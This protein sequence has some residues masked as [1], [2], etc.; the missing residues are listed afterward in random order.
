MARVAAAPSDHRSAAVRRMRPDPAELTVAE[1]I[2]GLRLGELAPA[3]RPYL[4]ANMVSSVDG[5]AAFRGRTKELGT[6]VD[7]EMF[8]RLRTHADAILVGAH[9]VRVERYGRMV[10]DP[11]LREQRVREGLVPDPLA[12]IVSGRLDLPT[13]TTLF[14]DPE[15][16]VA[17]YTASPGE[18]PEAPAQVTVHRLEPEEMTLGAVLRS[19]RTDHAVRSVLCEGGPTTLGF[20]L[21][22][23]LVDELFL[24]L[25]PTLAGGRQ[26][27]TIVTGPSLPDLAHLELVWVLE[28]GDELFLR[29]RVGQR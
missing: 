9:T 26:A 25:S 6:D 8:L 18:L 11:E 28:A 7:R 13:D 27:P 5:K 21:S 3:D 15:S 20:L 14:Q 29:Y 4:V 2:S 10:G 24:T 22:D 19:L 16:R 23:G 12:V 1:A 17:V